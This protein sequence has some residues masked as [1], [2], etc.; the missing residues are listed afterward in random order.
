MLDLKIAEIQ[1]LKEKRLELIERMRLIESLQE[2]RISTVHLFD[3][4]VRIVPTGVYL[5]EVQRTGDIVLLTGKADSNS[6][7]SELMRN[8]ERSVWLAQ[9]VLTEIKTNE[10]SNTLTRDFQ[11]EMEILNT[12]KKGEATKGLSRQSMDLNELDFDNIGS[13]PV[14]IKIV[15]VSLCCVILLILSIWFLIKPE[16]RKLDAAKQTQAELLQTYEFKYAQAANLEAYQKQLKQIQLL[17][18][19]MLGQLPNSSEVPS[20]IE[21]IS[22]LG[23]ANGLDFELIKPEDEI[24]KDFVTIMPIKIIVEGHYHQ[25]AGF[26]SDISTLQRIVAFDDF[27][28]KRPEQ[29]QGTQIK[30]IGPEDKLIMDIMAKTF[31][32]SVDYGVQK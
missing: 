4:M 14:P 19:S 23:V 26:V 6:R 10:D 8:I 22:K 9:P 20:L 17:F 11:L 15:F 5:L 25:L 16:L 13:W 27:T 1:K 12:P 24:D 7:V 31:R 32:Y 18:G 2:E 3:E 29:K 21:D 30:K 28:I